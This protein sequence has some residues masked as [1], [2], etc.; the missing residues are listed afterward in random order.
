MKKN[1]KN[2]QFEYLGNAEPTQVS[3]RL[4]TGIVRRDPRREF[5]NL[6]QEQFFYQ[7]PH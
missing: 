1:P 3:Q 4:R 2:N 6:S 7:M 5:L